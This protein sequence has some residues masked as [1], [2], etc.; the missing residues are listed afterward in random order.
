MPSTVA[1]YKQRPATTLNQPSAYSSS[2][3]SAAAATTAAELA[4]H[5]CDLHQQG[6]AQAGRQ[7][8]QVSIAACALPAG[9][10]HRHLGSARRLCDPGPHATCPDTW[11]SAHRLCSHTRPQISLPS[12]PV[13]AAGTAAAARLRSS[14]CIVDG[15]EAFMAM[16]SR[17][18]P[19][20]P[21]VNSCLSVVSAEDC[22][23]APLAVTGL[24][25]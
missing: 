6:V 16:L 5:G 11:L 21:L 22:L 15:V 7:P 17:S 25:M 1:P 2:S 12:R 23:L 13:A 4:C 8:I 19:F 14:T 9:N 24:W 3:V 20:Q 18:M 10:P